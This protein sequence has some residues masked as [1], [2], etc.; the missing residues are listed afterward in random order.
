[1]KPMKIDF[2]VH[3]NFSPDSQTPM[4]EMIERAIALGITDM[5]FTDHVDLE[6][7]P[8]STIPVWDFNK[9]DYFQAI[10]KHKDTYKDRIRLYAGVEIGLQP[11]VAIENGQI[12]SHWPFDYVLGSLHTVEKED[13][14][15]GDFLKMYPPKDAVFKYYE[16]YLEN[17]NAFSNIDCLGHLDLYLRY[18]DASKNVPFKAYSDVLEAL[19]KQAIHL[20]KGIEVN[21]GGHRYGLGQ[22][23]QSDQ[24][25]SIYHALGG[26]IITLGSDAHYTN[27]LG[28]QHDENAHLLKRIGFKYVCTFEN[29]TP[30]F[31]PL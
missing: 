13:L 28:A 11:H 12:V 15:S 24:I 5:A 10:R 30:M 26:E 21:A 9:A 3:S 31:H 29:R 4:T 17:L 14:C 27:T 20:G 16:A 18:S 19:L 6:S 8:K 23:N 7:D 22:N 2:H 25:L 1:M